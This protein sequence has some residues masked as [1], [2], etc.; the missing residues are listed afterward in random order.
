MNHLQRKY[1]YWLE[2]I[3]GIGALTIQRL[4][5]RYHNA[6]NIYELSEC[7]GKELKQFLNQTQLHFYEE[8]KKK[9]PE[10]LYKE[11]LKVGMNYCIREDREYPQRLRV[12]TDAPLGLFYYGELPDTDA[13]SVAV[14]GARLCSDYGRHVARTFARKLAMSGIQVISGLAQG[15]D[16]VAQ[17]ATLEAGGK[18][19]AV[20]GCGADICYPKE[21]GALYEA[22]KKQ[23]GIISEYLPGTPPKAGLFPMRNRIISGLSDAILVVEAREKSGTLITAD[24]ALEQGRDV[25]VIPGRVTDALSRGC[26]MLIRQ[27]AEAILSPEELVYQIWEQWE[28]RNPMAKRKKETD[29]EGDKVLKNGC[30]MSLEEEMVYE[31]LSYDAISLEGMVQKMQEKHPEFGME[32]ITV[33]LMGLCMKGVAV[34]Q[35]GRYLRK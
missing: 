26:N 11:F 24:R 32:E 9:N 27:G 6:Q 17:K 4:L 29:K 2:S 19:V 20:M 3:P 30:V 23:G 12:L 22:L 33:L 25:Y 21:N 10:N 28:F 14:V 31:Q 8:W 18:S 1:Q 34:M 16:S 35:Q 5:E 15:I 7:E 13:P